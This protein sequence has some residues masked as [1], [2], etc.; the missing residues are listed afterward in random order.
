[1]ASPI[2]L[3]VCGTGTSAG[4]LFG[5]LALLAWDLLTEYL[6]VPWPV[7]RWIAWAFIAGTVYLNVAAAHGDPAAS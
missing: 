6:R 7:L 1:M 3:L 4:H 5:I 2:P